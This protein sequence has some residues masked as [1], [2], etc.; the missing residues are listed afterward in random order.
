VSRR[1]ALVTAAGSMVQTVS[2]SSNW[3]ALAI[4][5]PSWSSARL[6][7]SKTSSSWPPTALQNSTADW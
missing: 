7:P 1:R 3:G 4:T 5:R 6:W 2:D